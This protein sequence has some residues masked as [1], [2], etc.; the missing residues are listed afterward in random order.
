[1]CWNNTAKPPQSEVEECLKV[2]IRPSERQGRFK[3][4]QKLSWRPRVCQRG[5][6]STRQT[7]R[8]TDRSALRA[9]DP[10]R[11]IQI[12]TQQESHGHNNSLPTQSTCGPHLR[13]P[14]RQHVFH[15][16]SLSSLEAEKPLHTLLP[17]YSGKHEVRAGFL[18][19][20]SF[21]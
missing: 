7:D 21:S 13:S 1:M 11:K 6:E 3:H 15:A 10:P 12:T 16:P 8:Q 19:N 18:V 20:P 9:D 17:T 4:Y 2:Q 5:E 14:Q